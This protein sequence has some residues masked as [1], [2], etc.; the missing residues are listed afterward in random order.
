M[1]IEFQE[2]RPIKAYCI[3]DC[4]PIFKN[5]YKL[6]YGPKQILWALRATKV[7]DGN[8]NV[9]QQYV[10]LNYFVLAPI[11]ILKENRVVNDYN[12]LYLTRRGIV[13]VARNLQEHLVVKFKMPEKPLAVLFIKD[14]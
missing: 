5:K 7:I 8:N 10:D 2:S 12:R 9:L 14:C 11:W 4:M 6:P 3:K 13:F 1:E